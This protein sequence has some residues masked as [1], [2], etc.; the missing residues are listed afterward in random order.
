LQ[1]VHAARATIVLQDRL[2]QRSFHATQDIIVRP[3]R[4]QQLKDFAPPSFFVLALVLISLL[5]LLVLIALGWAIPYLRLVL[6]DSSALHHP[7]HLSIVQLVYTALLAYRFLA[8]T[9]IIARAA[10]CQNP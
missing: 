6:Q 9:S 8:A 2:L 1:V 5:A 7:K 3:H 10:M 4:H